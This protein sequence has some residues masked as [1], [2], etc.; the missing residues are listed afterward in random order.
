MNLIKTPKSLL[1]VLW[2]LHLYNGHD[3]M[4]PALWI[5]S[6]PV[7][8]LQTLAGGQILRADHGSEHL[9]HRW[10]AADS[11]MAVTNDALI[12]CPVPA[13][14]KLRMGCVSIMLPFLAVLFL[15]RIDH[16]L[17]CNH[18]YLVHLS[19]N[20]HQLTKKK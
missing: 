1:L 7:G 20:K 9:G 13:Y 3:A 11:N 12:L 18:H 14:L 4:T 2:L 17:F 8:T 19:L 15:V 10:S 6:D 16:T 5:G